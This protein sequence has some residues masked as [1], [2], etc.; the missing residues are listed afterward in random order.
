[1]ESRGLASPGDARSARR[2]GGPRR[3]PCAWIGRWLIENRIRSRPWLFPRRSRSVPPASYAAQLKWAWPSG[4]FRASSREA[5]ALIL[6]VFDP[7]VRCGD[8]A[9]P[10][11]PWPSG[12]GG[13]RPRP[14]GI[15]EMFHFG[16]PDRDEFGHGEAFSRNLA[17]AKQTS[18][19]SGHVENQPQGVCR[20]VM[21]GRADTSIL[22]GLADA[23][24][25]G[26]R[27][28][29]SGT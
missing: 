21:M 11:W 1:M 19:S 14:G 22:R 10:R 28:L 26:R 4:Y 5:S 27:P 9:A 13:L 15:K 25:D 16:R 6:V 23:P 2:D 29:R 24:S 17:S 8:A 18:Q 12:E 7:S 3:I 20:Q